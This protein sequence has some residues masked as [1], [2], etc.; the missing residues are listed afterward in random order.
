MIALMIVSTALAAADAGAPAKAAPE[1]PALTPQMT[2]ALAELMAFAS[3]EAGELAPLTADKAFRDVV[4][5][6]VTADYAK[7]WADDAKLALG[8][9]PK[10]W[11]TLRSGWA[12]FPEE[13]KNKLRG[14]WR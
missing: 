3:N 13:K 6:T 7:G 10:D 1:I 12:G 11:A 14:E 9:L 5:K 2:A 4:A 8:D